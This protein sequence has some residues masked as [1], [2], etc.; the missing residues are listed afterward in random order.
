MWVLLQVEAVAMVEESDERLFGRSSEQHS[1][2]GVDFGTVQPV[3]L[4]GTV[5][6]RVNN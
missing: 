2:T 1:L 6:D 4:S 3:R 5:T